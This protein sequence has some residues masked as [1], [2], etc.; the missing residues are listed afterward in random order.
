M[1]APAAWALRGCVRIAL[2]AI[3][4]PKRSV[5]R[6]L[7][8]QARQVIREQIY[9]PT[10][11][12]RGSESRESAAA[13]FSQSR[14]APD[15]SLVVYP[16]QN[17]VLFCAG[18][19]WD[20]IDWGLIEALRHACN[21]RVVSVLY[22]LIPIK[23][24]DMIPQSTDHYVNYFL[25]LL[26]ECDLAFCISASSQRDFIEFAAA[27][28]RRKPAT[29]ILRLGANVPAAPRPD[30][31][32]DPNL[33]DRLR[34]GRFALTVGTFEVRKNYRLLIDLWHELAVDHTFD[35]DLVIVG[36]AGWGVE[37]TLQQLRASPLLGSRIFWLQGVSDA[38]LSWLYET[39]HL[40]LYPS[41]YEGWGL[42]IVEALQRKR[43]VIASNRGAVPEAALGAAT[44][45][46]PDDR[47]AWRNAI[48]AE[49]LTARRQVLVR[50]IPTWDD[51]SQA[52]RHRL[53]DLV[54]QTEIRV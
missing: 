50:D 23:F 21:L 53:S 47:S 33:R 13:L 1:I 9:T 8:I 38:G 2:R 39:C 28:G 11:T 40:L 29:E 16:R 17:D 5:A 41:L 10:G 51:A 54:S 36:M 3:P 14:E 26:D 6:Q 46:D 20:V 43:P 15:L 48:I 4:E 27:M 42:P 22:D 45:I 35:L 30:E 52:V 19:G 44:I 7:L 24:P 32:S 12:A 37:E 25:H 18:L 31:F 34:R 49:A